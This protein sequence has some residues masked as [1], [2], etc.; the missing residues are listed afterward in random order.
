MKQDKYEISHKNFLSY[1][2]R[3]KKIEESLRETPLVELETPIQKGW[4]VSI[5]LRKD[6]SRRED[7]VEILRL[8][9][10][11]YQKEYIT[12]EEKY[13]KLIRN[14]KKHYSFTRDKKKVYV[15]FV[16]HKKRIDEKTYDT[17]TEHLKTYFYLDTLDYSYQKRK[18]KSY[19][20]DIPD[21]WIELKCRPNMLTHFRAKGG[22]LEKELAFL[23][24]K[25]SEYWLTV[26]GGYGKSFPKTKQRTETR[27]K[28]KKFIKGEI[29]DIDMNKKVPLECRD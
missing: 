18:I 10:L 13:V 17:F 5:R 3:I 26:G 6:I 9:E 29:E 8:I 22:K 21:F 19:V 1:K 28:I 20:I 4:V 15:H 12:K 2:K 16:P 23:E 25:V 14:G 27:A 24:D 7:S 11:G